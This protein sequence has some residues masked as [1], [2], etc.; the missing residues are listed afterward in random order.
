MYL[1]GDISILVPAV[2]SEIVAILTAPAVLSHI[3]FN[4]KMLFKKLHLR[5]LS[6]SEMC[7]SAIAAL[8][9]LA[10]MWSTRALSSGVQRQYTA[11]QIR[12]KERRHNF[13]K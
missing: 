5:E 7:G 3:I 8:S 9:R 4:E 13:H 6:P 12:S 11:E 2:F 10:H 1:R